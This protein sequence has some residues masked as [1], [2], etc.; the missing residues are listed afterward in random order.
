[1]PITDPNHYSLLTTLIDLLFG[2]SAGIAAIVLYDSLMRI[3]R[4]F[5]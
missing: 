3:W 5:K 2:V 4:M 1:M